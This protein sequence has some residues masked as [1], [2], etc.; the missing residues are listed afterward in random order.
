MMW[1][2][3][4]GNEHK[5]RNERQAE[6]ARYRIQLVLPV[7]LHNYIGYINVHHCVYGCS[8]LADLWLVDSVVGDCVTADTEASCS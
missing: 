7:Y 3:F 2:C 8:P 5:C 1:Q 4:I 6:S